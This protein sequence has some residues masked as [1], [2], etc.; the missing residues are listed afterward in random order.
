MLDEAKK[1]TKELLE[2]M[3]VDSKVSIEEKEGVIHIN[4]ESEDSGLLIGYHGETLQALQLLLGMMVNQGRQEWQ[5][6][7]V[8]IGDYREQREEV[9]ARMA[10]RAAERAR[11]L[12]E[13]Q[14][15]PVMPAYERRLVHIAIAQEEGVSSE[16]AGTGRDRRVVVKPS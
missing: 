2:K 8:D 11:D 14:E 15:L 1:L 3:D 16:S 4:I 6:T 13:E 12:K 10:R 5:R 9:L 7:I